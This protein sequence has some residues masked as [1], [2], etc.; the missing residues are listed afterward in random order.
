MGNEQP[1]CTFGKLEPDFGALEKL[2]K[3]R[4]NTDLRGKTTEGSSTATEYKPKYVMTDESTE[5]KLK[6]LNEF[7]EIFSGKPYEGEDKLTKFSQIKLMDFSARDICKK[8]LERIKPESLDSSAVQSKIL[9]YASFIRG[10]LSD[11]NTKYE[12]LIQ[13]LHKLFMFTDDDK[14]IV[15]PALNDLED[16]DSLTGTGREY[17][18]SVL[19]AETR[20]IIESMYLDCE[21]NFQIGVQKFEDIQE[22]I[23]NKDNMTDE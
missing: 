12:S 2:Y 20:K 6:I 17:N 15:H 18:L 16:V 14:V 19:V 9:D 7:Y 3:T 1:K 21:K 10:M 4:F 11:I 22:E 13:I 23:L 8:D 5:E